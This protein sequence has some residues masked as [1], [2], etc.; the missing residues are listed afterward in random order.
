AGAGANTGAARRRGN[1]RRL[2]AHEDS[3][4]RGSSHP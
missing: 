4:T 2:D 1:G 3:S